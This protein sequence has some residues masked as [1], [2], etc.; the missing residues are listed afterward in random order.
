MEPF[1]LITG[2]FQFLA[3]LKT[4]FQ[5]LSRWN[6][7][8]QFKM[9]M[10]LTTE[11]HNYQV[12]WSREPKLQLV[13]TTL[14]SKSISTKKAM[15]ITSNRKIKQSRW[16]LDLMPM[17]CQ[18]KLNLILWQRTTHLRPDLMPTQC[19][20]RCQ[21][22][23]IIRRCHMNDCLIIIQQPVLTLLSSMTHQRNELNQLRKLLD[24]P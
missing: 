22:P 3:K 21:I 6:Q 4:Q 12:V 2:V 20:I 13:K 23:R 5:S 15:E 1:S 17:T 9:K 8:S 16:Q 10:I 19:T 7:F 11:N 14:I 18:F 24:S